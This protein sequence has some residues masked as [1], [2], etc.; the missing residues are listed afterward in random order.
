MKMTGKSAV[1]A[2]LFLVLTACRDTENKIITESGVGNITWDQIVSE[3]GTKRWGYT[4]A[5]DS[6][7]VD[8]REYTLYFVLK[9]KAGD[10]VMK[11]FPG[12]S[13]EIYSPD[14]ET[15]SGIHAGMN[16]HEAARLVGEEHFRIWLDWPNDYFTVG[17]REF[18]SIDWHVSGDQMIGG[19][20]AFRAFSMSGTGELR[21]SDFKPE[22]RIGWMTVTRED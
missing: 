7:C 13:V 16:L 21:I 9:D 5:A 4:V 20:D 22:A 14:F 19:W 17:N 3:P 11:I 6:L 2:A 8:G 18:G 1:M 10:P 12:E 15:E